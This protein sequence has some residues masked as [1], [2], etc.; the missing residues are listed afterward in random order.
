MNYSYEKMNYLITYLVGFFGQWSRQLKASTE[1][2]EMCQFL[3]TS[4]PIQV[5]DCS[6]PVTDAECPLDQAIAT[7]DHI[8]TL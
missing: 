2:E 8:L 3:D 1:Q 4:R 6:C 5:R 7:L